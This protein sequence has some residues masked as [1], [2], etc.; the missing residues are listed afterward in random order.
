VPQ[1]T[2]AAAAPTTTPAPI[3][4]HSRQAAAKS[5]PDPSATAARPAPKVEK[6]V[7]VARHRPAPAR[8]EAPV[9]AEREEAAV[10]PRA[11]SPL[12]MRAARAVLPREQGGV[13][14]ALRVTS[15]ATYVTPDGR[16]VTMNV[17]PSSDVVRALVQR[18]TQAY[19]S[20]RT[21]RPYWDW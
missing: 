7:R 6:P 1:D 14:P 16:L 11:P 19:A 10:V 20:P 13:M 21:S 9:V 12:R 2:R 8:R 15:T 4:K 18:H 17:A 5:A 3:A